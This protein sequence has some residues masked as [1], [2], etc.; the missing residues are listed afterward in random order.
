MKIL[1][2]HTKFRRWE[3]V[4]GTNKTLKFE[5]AHLTDV[6]YLVLHTHK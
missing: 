3:V 5:L 1:L 6:F 4:A 2:R